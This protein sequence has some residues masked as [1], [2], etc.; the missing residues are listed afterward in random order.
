MLQIIINGRGGQGA[1]TM[2]MLL[3]EAAI[4]SNKYAI[5]FPEFGP[6]RT[7][8]PVKAYL[9]IDSDEILTR[10]PIQKPDLLI[11]LDDTLLNNPAMGEL[12][13]SKPDLLINSSRPAEELQ[14]KINQIA[15]YEKKPEIVD[16][17]KIVREADKKVHFSAPIFARLF[18]I[19]NFLTLEEFTEVYRKKFERKLGKE[20]VGETIAVM[21][22]AYDQI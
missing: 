3:A 14:T 8:A 1:K 17:Q 10:E 7:G 15:Q 21:E 2:A 9:R 12:L 11:V 16:A 5:A 13:K 4:G 22:K 6:E 20:T 18:K 19:R